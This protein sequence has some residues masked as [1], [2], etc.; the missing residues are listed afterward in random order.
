MTVF[1]IGFTKKRAQ[2]FFELIKTN[3][4]KQLVDIRLNT[5]S[6]LAGFSKG[7]DLEYFLEEICGCGY[8]H[9]MIFAPTKELKDNFKS[10]KISVIQFE[11]DYMQLLS[12]RNAL[13]YFH[14]QYAMMD[15]ICLLCSEDT[16]EHCHRRILAEMIAG[17]YPGT[18]IKHI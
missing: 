15:N 11:N 16:P 8:C 18:I 17:K 9:E 7:N 12:D 6:Q 4:I 3:E 1:T 2:E 14:K 13:N 5:N 10:K